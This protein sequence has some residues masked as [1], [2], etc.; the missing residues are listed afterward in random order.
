MDDVGAVCAAHALVQL[1]EAEILA[2]GMKSDI[3]S[4]PSNLVLSLDHPFSQF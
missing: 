1:D 4:S 2:I 3:M